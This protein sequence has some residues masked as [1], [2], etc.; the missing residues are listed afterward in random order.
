M[1]GK[2]LSE[3]ENNFIASISHFDDGSFGFAY[4]DLSTG[5]NK[6]T[7]LNGIILMKC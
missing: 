2:G 3:K 7:L 1:E 6:A 5:E 4:T